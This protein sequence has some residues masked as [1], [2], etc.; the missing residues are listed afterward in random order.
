VVV[1]KYN[2]AHQLE[3]NEIV[4]QPCQNKEEINNMIMTISTM[5]KEHINEVQTDLTQ[6]K[7][8]RTY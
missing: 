8:R 6:M 4:I 1:L 3:E 7:R 2:E 5:G